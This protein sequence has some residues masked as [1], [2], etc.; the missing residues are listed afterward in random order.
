MQFTHQTLASTN[1]DTQGERLSKAFLV[2]F[3]EQMNGQRF[4][5]HQQHDMSMPVAGYIENARIVEDPN[6]PGEYQLVGDVYVEAGTIADVLGGF[7][8]SGMEM[9]RRSESGTALVYV[10]FPQYNDPEL[11]AEL[12]ADPDLNVGRWIKKAAEPIGWIV[13][14]SVLAFA[15]T[16]V[17]DDVY[18]RKIA[19]RIDELLDRLLPLFKRKNLATELVQIVLFKDVEVEVRILPVKGKEAICL[20]SSQVNQG[21]GAVVAF[22]GN[23]QK[24]NNVGVKRIVIFFDNGVSAYKIHR[25]EYADGAVQHVA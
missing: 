15:V 11:M 22:L 5:V 18:K 17:W 4:P 24:A 13:L 19:P 25:I 8:I 1:L 3:C 21:M 16:P 6:H 9:L 23:D 7:S 12:I 2:R 14:G 20:Q 10:P